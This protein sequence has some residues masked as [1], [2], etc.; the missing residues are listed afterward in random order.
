MF[1]HVMAEK[2]RPQFTEYDLAA[3]KP[4]DSS[5]KGERKV[6]FG[7][8]GWTPTKI[9]DMDGLK[10]GNVVEG[11]SIIEHPMTTLV[12]PPDAQVDFDKY[13]FIEYKRK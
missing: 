10:A 1:V 3:P 4:D 8:D 5:L 13:R 6:Y 12:V 9:Y 2:Q 11:P 7:T